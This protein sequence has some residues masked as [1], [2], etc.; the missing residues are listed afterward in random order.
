MSIT[1][2]DYERKDYEEHLIKHAEK[3]AD[4]EKYKVYLDA[5]VV[6][7]DTY[8][9]GY[10]EGFDVGYVQ[11]LKDSPKEGVTWE[12]LVTV[13]SAHFDEVY[14]IDNESSED[15]VLRSSFFAGYYFG[16][17]FGF[18]KKSKE[19]ARSKIVYPVELSRRD[20]MWQAAHI[21]SGDIFVD[22]VKIN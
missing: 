17:G 22:G 19:Y 1:L 9:K 8:K 7:L 14:G 16:Q 21:E 5:Y 11:G 2:N 10:Y 18:L 4:K 13:Y 12:D 20:A 3:I 6:A 15:D